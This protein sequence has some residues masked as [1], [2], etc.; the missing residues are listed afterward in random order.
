MRMDI[1]KGKLGK[2]SKEQVEQLM[3]ENEITDNTERTPEEMTLETWV[4][5]GHKLDWTMK[6]IE[7][8]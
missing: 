3:K 8:E 6:Q 1:E 2:Y 5:I 7:E 4:V